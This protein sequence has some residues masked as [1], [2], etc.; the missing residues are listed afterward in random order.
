M[1]KG[2]KED[3]NQTVKSKIIIISIII[4]IIASII[5]GFVF[6]KD[7]SDRRYKIESITE[8]SYFKVYENEKYG[9][10]DTKGNILVEP[11]YDMLIIPNPSKAIFVGYFNYDSEKGEYQTEV[12]NE[13]NEKILTN[14][15]QILPLMFKDAIVEVP[16]EKS[17]LSYKENGKYGIIDFEGKK[18][19][20]A[21]Y[22]SIESLLYREGCLLVKQNEKYGIINIKGKELV[23]V[24]YD[25][26]MAD[27]YYEEE[28]KYQ[29][30]GFIVGQKKEDGYR[31]GYIGANGEEI[32]DVEYNEI[33]RITEI[34]DNDIYILAFKNGQAGVYKSNKQIIKHSYEEIEYSQ[35]NKL[36]IV[37]KNNKQGVINIEGS[38]VLDTIYDYI[39]IS[40][41]TI[42]AQK[43]DEIYYFDINGNKKENQ[44]KKTIM[45]T[46]NSKYYIAID[47]ND[48][49]TITNKEGNNI[50]ENDFS[51]IE[52]A[53]D[54]YF[55][56]NKNNKTSLINVETK[57]E[58][59]SDYNV[60]QKI[61]NKNVIQA[62]ITKPYTIEIYNKNMEKVAS[63]QD[64]NLKIEKDYIELYSKTERKYFNTNG[65]EIQNKE[66]FSNVE[67]FAF[68]NE[69]GKWGFENK[70]GNV[71]IEAKYDMVTELNF[72]GFA[73][74]MKNN[75]WGVI[76][77]NGEVIVEPTYEIE[78]LNPEFIGPYLKLNF[79]YG[80]VYYTKDI[81]E[82]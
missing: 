80:M 33:A 39:M 75:K 34:I 66:I 31:Y 22:D 56:V 29:K 68:V 61:E 8:F 81:N 79:G 41:S 16:Y 69:N 13:K 52:Y 74:I 11:K 44:N 48:K 27:G 65:D 60:I 59:I 76:N 19:T 21:I 67:L 70:D 4:I 46:E 47:Q 2:I 54:N 25:Y 9:V 32:L 78:W 15:N 35:I 14:Y 58:I 45:R 30:A 82:Q 49:F 63:M 55:I 57:E 62:V 43:E 18:I 73:G 20:D 36:F 10:I 23:E 17:I 12:I 28:T 42:N 71:V 5:V 26:I 53:F 72:Y 3:K 51:Y 40:E 24:E 6:W 1:E 38:Q 37:Q 50:L 64:A 77:S 7:Y